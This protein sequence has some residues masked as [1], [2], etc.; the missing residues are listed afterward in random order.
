[1]NEYIQKIRT[2]IS[3]GKIKEA[4]TLCSD[5]KLDTVQS[6]ALMALQSR[7]TEFREDWHS[8][9]FG[10]NDLR[11]VGNRITS[12]FL[13]WVSDLTPE[14]LHLKE[15]KETIVEAKNSEI[16]LSVIDASE[17][18]SINLFDLSHHIANKEFMKDNHDVFHELVSEYMTEY[19]TFFDGI[20][21]R[22]G[23]YW[24]TYFT[25]QPKPFFKQM[26]KHLKKEINNCT[27]FNAVNKAIR[28]D[29]KNL[30]DLT[31]SQKV[32]GSLLLTSKCIDF[33]HNQYIPQNKL[34][35]DFLAFWN[36]IMGKIFGTK[37]FRM[38]E[39]K[40]ILFDESYV[41][42][43]ILPDKQRLMNLLN[44]KLGF[45]KDKIKVI[46]K[47]LEWDF[48][49][50]AEMPKFVIEDLRLFFDEKTQTEG[51][52][53]P[54]GKNIMP[55]SEQRILGDF[56]TLFREIRGIVLKNKNKDE[57]YEKLEKRYVFLHEATDHSRFNYYAM[58][59]LVGLAQFWLINSEKNFL[60]KWLE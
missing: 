51:F 42:P 31:E 46:F 10:D 8:G 49:N 41:S 18:E 50:K 16:P 48:K 9:T 1:M 25:D 6:D 30:K 58:T 34:R 23:D 4:F 56:H 37:N 2:Q 26:K 11:P 33:T 38:A 24:A 60:G 35:E 45:L 52:F 3:T 59:L 53:N 57:E 14:F 36:K 7:Y 13:F 27:L 12:D 20:P 29:W 39:L 47:V 22:L 5:I 28:K 19:N 21:D 54:K 55:I 17:I 43:L 32:F 44:E 40:Q 15:R